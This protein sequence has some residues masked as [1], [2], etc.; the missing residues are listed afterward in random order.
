MTETIKAHRFEAA[1]LGVAPFRYVGMNDN[2]RQNPDGSMQALGTCDYCGTGIRYEFNVEDSTGKTF[3]V[4]CE[5]IRHAFNDEALVIVVESE[6]RKLA[7]QKREVVR[8]QKRLQWLAENKPRLEAE[9]KAFEERQRIQKETCLKKW[10]FML[11]ILNGMNGGFVQSIMNGIKNG[12]EPYGSAIDIL[13]DIY[14]KTFGRRGSNA[15]E[16]AENEFNLRINI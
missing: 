9:Q 15:Y 6:K 8:E 2:S 5:C 11:E 14:S 16:Q 13:R 12:N 3:K 1:H 4:G 7:R 10:G